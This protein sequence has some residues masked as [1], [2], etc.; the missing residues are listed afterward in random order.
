MDSLFS[1][2]SSAARRAFSSVAFFSAAD[3]QINVLDKAA[4]PMRK[5]GRLLIWALMDVG[6]CR[7]F[8]AASASRCCSASRRSAS[9]R[10]SSFFARTRRRRHHRWICT[11][12]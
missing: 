12:K 7:S 8:A 4:R 11:A 10:S 1:P 9:R 6:G 2:S 5:L 3:G